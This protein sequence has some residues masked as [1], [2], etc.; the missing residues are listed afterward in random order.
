MSAIAS[1]AGSTRNKLLW[2]E[3]LTGLACRIVAMVQ[4]MSSF[5]QASIY[6]DDGWEPRNLRLCHTHQ[7][8]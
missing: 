4:D 6:T 5:Y 1:R 8:S 3:L 7:L 2:G